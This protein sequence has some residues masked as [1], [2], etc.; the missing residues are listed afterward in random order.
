RFFHWILTTPRPE[1]LLPTIR[2]R[3]VGVVLARESRAERMAAWISRGFSEEDAAE[4]AGLEPESE[5]EAPARLEEPRKWRA[6]LLLALENGISRRRIAPLLLLAEALAHAKP[7]QTRVF[8]E[9]LADAAVAS[10]SS[11][12]RLRHRAVAGGIRD[13]ARRLTP[14]G[15]SRATLKAADVPP[16]TRRGNKRLHY[17]SLLLELLRS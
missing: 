7:D 15:L 5:E 17:E 12:E 1:A 13:L 3:C 8:S 11:S 14:E 2:S 10:A 4:L 16:D 6:D 9:I